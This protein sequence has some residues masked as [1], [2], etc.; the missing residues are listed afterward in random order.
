MRKLKVVAPVVIFLAAMV[1]SSTMSYAK[2][3]MTKKE[4]K[5]CITCHVAAKSKD[6]NDTGK[7]YK[8]KNTLAGCEAKK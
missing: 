1:G 4:K 7:C 3:E 8:E 2:P 5:P 6:L